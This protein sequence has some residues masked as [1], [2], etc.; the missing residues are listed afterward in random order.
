MNGYAG[1][2]FWG[3]TPLLYSFNYQEFNQTNQLLDKETGLLPGLQLAYSHERNNDMIRVQVMLAEGEVDYDGQT[4]G[5]TPHTT[6]T[7]TQLFRIAT[8][9]YSDQF[10]LLGA[11]FFFGLQHWRWDRD[12]LTRNNVLGL[13]EIYTWNEMEIGLRYESTTDMLSSNWLEV[14]GFYT[15]NPNMDIVLPSGKYE[16]DLG[17]EPGLRLRAGRTWTGKNHLDL[18]LSLFLEYWQFGRSNTIYVNDFYGSPALLVEP[19]SESL[20][21]GIAFNISRRI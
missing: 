14:S 20:H 2:N 9:L 8:H 13:H 19:R 7:K 6:D 21:T 5:G 17:K 18:S 12:I 1:N 16:L 11:R 15:F 4:Q 10:D 3:I